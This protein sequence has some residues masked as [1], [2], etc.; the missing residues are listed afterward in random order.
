[1]Q[2]LKL[3]IIFSLLTIFLAG[4]TD[5]PKM[6][7]K[8]DYFIETITNTEKGY[9]LSINYY[10]MKMKFNITKHGSCLSNGIVK[11][12]VHKNRKIIYYINRGWSC[13]LIAIFHYEDEEITKKVYN[14][15][16]LKEE[17]DII[18]KLIKEA[19]ENPQ[20]YIKL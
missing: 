15:Y 14:H 4:C 3:F 18:K 9:R 17:G 19:I 11:S 8:K 20:K 1:M 16:I 10:G 12:K 2:V 5:N 7:I 6:P 13:T